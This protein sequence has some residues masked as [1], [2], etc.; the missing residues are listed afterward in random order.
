[1]PQS[2]P[3]DLLIRSL[4]QKQGRG[5]AQHPPGAIQSNASPVGEVH[6]N[7][8]GRPNIAKP[9]MGTANDPAELYNFQGALGDELAASQINASA[10]GDQPN[11]AR[12]AGFGAL[13]KQAMARSPIPAQQAEYDQRG[14]DSRQALDEGFGMGPSSPTPNVNP[15]VSRN[16]Y[17]RQIAQEEMRQ[18]VALKE[19]E[20]RG[21][22]QRQNIS[23]GATK[24]TA[25]RN[26]EAQTD[27][28]SQFNE[29]MTMVQ[30]QGGKIDNFTLPN[31]GGG[32]RIDLANTPPPPNTTSS[33]N[34]MVVIR[35]NLAKAGGQL[36]INDSSS[37]PQQ[38]AY[39]AAAG[40]EIARSQ[41]SPEDKQMIVNIMRDPNEARKTIPELF[42][43]ND[44][45]MTS[46]E[47]NAMMNLFIKLRG[48]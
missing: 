6:M 11:A 29:L 7:I 47:Y 38:Q 36:W 18:P 25:D 28:A 44:P 20:E 42:D 32:G 14:F 15:L 22:T 34:Q 17:K 39:N 26:Y 37:N 48:F 2:N 43:I 16:L 27:R 33:D 24:Y 21:A 19:L 1:M 5:Q 41:L 40:N 46:Q 8:P 31:K 4:A 10:F 45:S 23:S 12:F 30:G 3:L 9:G 35:Q 13:N